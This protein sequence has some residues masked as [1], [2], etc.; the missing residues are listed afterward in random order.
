MAP[1][2]PVMMAHHV[3]AAAHCFRRAGSSI[4]AGQTAAGPC[5]AGLA[6]V[7]RQRRNG[8]R[9]HAGECENNK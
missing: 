5:G 9:Q 7:L 1:M 3:V 4:A 2:M 8:I 6:G